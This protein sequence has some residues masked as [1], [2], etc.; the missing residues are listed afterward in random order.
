[1]HSVTSSD[2]S[3]EVVAAK[4]FQDG[5]PPAEHLHAEHVHEGVESSD[6]HRLHRSELVEDQVTVSGKG[7]ETLTF[8]KYS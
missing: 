3:I 2:F 5:A 4:H 8:L 7:K 1:M 6:G